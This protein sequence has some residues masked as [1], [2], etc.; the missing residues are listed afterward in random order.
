MASF[1]REKMK[2]DRMCIWRKRARESPVTASAFHRKCVAVV[3]CR[4]GGLWQEPCK[5]FVEKEHSRYGMHMCVRGFTEGKLVKFSE[6]QSV[7]LVFLSIK[8]HT[9]Q[10]PMLPGR[11]RESQITCL[12]S[13]VWS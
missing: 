3:C 10:L 12:E 6:L 4:E 13:W 11:W 9:Q 7:G 1:V 2:V 5:R 8:P